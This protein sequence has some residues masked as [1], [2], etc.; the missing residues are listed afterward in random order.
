MN[1]N[2]KRT[3][4]EILDFSPALRSH[5]ERLNRGWIE[6]YFEMEPLDYRLLQNPETEIIEKG[7][8]VL[9]AV[10]GGA[11]VG[12]VALKN[13]GDGVFELSKMAVD[14]NARGLGIGEALGAAALERARARGKSFCTPIRFSNRRSPCIASSVFATFRS[15]KRNTRAPT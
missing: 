4:V 11:V 5:F 12:T 10:T 13:D 8:A 9:F 1:E 6:R 3:D 14:E 15:R 7:G 2:K